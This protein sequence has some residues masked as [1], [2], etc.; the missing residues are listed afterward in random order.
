MQTPQPLPLKIFVADPAAGSRHNR[1]CAVDLT[2]FDLATGEPIE[3]TGGYDEMSPR[4]F[5]DYPG[6]TT[7]QRWHREL[8]RAAMEAEGFRV[9]PNEWWHFD[10]DDWRSYP[11]LESF[12]E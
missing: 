1:G 4:S 6:G 11:I 9:Y 7:R 12:P 3:M 2:L 5:P 8:L 10:Y